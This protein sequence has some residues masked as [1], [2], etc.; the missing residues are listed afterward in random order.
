MG[1]LLSDETANL[2]DQLLAEWQDTSLQPS[3]RFLGLPYMKRKCHHKHQANMTFWACGV[4]VSLFVGSSFEALLAKQLESL[5][6]QVSKVAAI[7]N[8]VIADVER[9]QRKVLRDRPDADKCILRPI[10]SPKADNE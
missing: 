4:N 3:S 2:V 5:V 1:G 6:G 7:W 10:V 8:P 9:M